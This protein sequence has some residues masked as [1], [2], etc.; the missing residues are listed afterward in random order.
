[1]INLHEIAPGLF[2]AINMVFHIPLGQSTT[3]STCFFYYRKISGVH[4]FHPSDLI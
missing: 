4:I 3:Y 2:S 1:M